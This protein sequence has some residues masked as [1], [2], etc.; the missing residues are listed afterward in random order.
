L[1]TL[2]TVRILVVVH[3]LGDIAKALNR[4]VT[5]LVAWQRRFALPLCAGAGYAEAYLGFLQRVSTLRTLNVSDELV[6][7]LWQLER[8][9]LTLLHVDSTGSPTWFL[10]SCGQTS[11]PERRL[12]LSNHD[13][14]RTLDART[15][16]L[17]LNFAEQ[18]SELFP[19]AAM[20]EDALRVL[21]EYLQSHE[22]AREAVQREL[23]NV[24]EA[25]RWAGKWK[26]K[27]KAREG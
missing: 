8:K 21:R 26:G 20:G 2:P 13:M 12:L 10:D 4:P 22:R 24:R 17:G 6:D 3:T 15:L 5:Q 19:G 18:P 11:H 7:K 9:L 1:R 25:A 23:P 14:G 16:Q 27:A